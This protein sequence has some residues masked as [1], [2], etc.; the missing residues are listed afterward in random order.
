[1]PL[2]FSQLHPIFAAEVSSVDLRTVRDRET[3]ERI[4]AGM[5]QYAVLVFRNQS[6]AIQ[7]QLAFAQRLDGSLHTKTG[8]AAL[9][10]SRLGEEAV[11]DVSNVG[12]DGKILGPEDRRRIYSL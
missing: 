7:E 5:D 4:R 12:A 6:F 9:V 2:T 3:L 1:M 10:K 8:I 11:A